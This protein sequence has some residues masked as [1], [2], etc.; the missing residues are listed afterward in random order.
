MGVGDW[1]EEE[2]CPLALLVVS[3]FHQLCPSPWNA[4]WPTRPKMDEQ[5]NSLV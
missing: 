4:Q 5:P 1:G 2:A 3:C